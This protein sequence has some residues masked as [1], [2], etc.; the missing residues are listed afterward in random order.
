MRGSQRTD[1]V[2]LHLTVMNSKW[3]VKEEEQDDVRRG[4][5]KERE[6]FDATQVFEV[7]NVRVLL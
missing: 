5:W 1:N 7:S 3:I 2:K 4:E 6:T